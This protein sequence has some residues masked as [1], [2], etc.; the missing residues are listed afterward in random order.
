MNAQL[1]ALTLVAVIVYNLYV[2]TL[3]APQTNAAHTVVKEA[4]RIAKIIVFLQFVIILVMVVD[5][6]VFIKK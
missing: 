2:I 3:V 1:F 6:P 5:V 4:N